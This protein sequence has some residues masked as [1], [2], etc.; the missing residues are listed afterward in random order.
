MENP[1]FW[2]LPKWVP[3]VANVITDA[4]TRPLPSQMVF[5]TE[6]TFQLLCTYFGSFNLDLMASTDRRNRKS[7]TAVTDFSFMITA[8][9]GQK[10]MFRYK[11]PPRSGVHTRQHPVYV[12]HLRLK[13]ATLFN[14]FWRSAG[15]GR[16]SSPSTTANTGYYVANTPHR[17]YKVAR[18]RYINLVI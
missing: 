13:L 2:L 9:S 15:R 1:P 8:R 4:I 10:S 5:L 16:P 18:R 7:R 11:A 6:S 3:T 12:S 14:F 17:L